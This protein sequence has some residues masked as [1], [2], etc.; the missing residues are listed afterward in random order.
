MGRTRVRKNEKS[1]VHV[2]MHMQHNKQNEWMKEP[3]K[4]PKRQSIIV[5]Q[6]QN[7]IVTPQK[8]QL[9]DDKKLE[10]EIILFFEEM[11]YEGVFEEEFLE[12]IF[13]Y[14]EESIIRSKRN[15]LGMLLEFMNN[16]KNEDYNYIKAM[17]RMF[18][19]K[20]VTD[21]KTYIMAKEEHLYEL[22]KN[23]NLEKKEQL[24][25]FFMMY[26]LFCTVRYKNEK[27]GQ[28]VLDEMKL[29]N[30]CFR[31]NTLLPALDGEL[32]TLLRRI[33]EKNTKFK[34]KDLFE[35]IRK[36]AV[37]DYAI[38][39]KNTDI[40]DRLLVAGIFAHDDCNLLAK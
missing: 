5:T 36:G 7:I 6:T 1:F 35:H 39:R 40:L 19:I 30:N 9:N 26:I 13:R 29:Y 37:V 12:G 2:Q 8:R 10:K 31:K 3:S 33:V 15:I 32:E 22:I 14:A 17:Y 24:R 21:K 28:I 18:P 25:Y 38:K 34:E 4:Q 27:L 16:K 23:S 11:E 20:G